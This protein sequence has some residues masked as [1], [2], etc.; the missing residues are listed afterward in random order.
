[1]A[2][3]QQPGFRMRKIAY[4]IMP[5]LLAI[6]GP[7]DA[8]PLSPQ[9]KVSEIYKL[10]TL[11]P[12]LKVDRKALDRFAMLN[13][14][15][16]TPGSREDRWFLRRAAYDLRKV[17]RQH[18]GYVCKQGMTRYGPEGGVAKGLMLTN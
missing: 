6:T 16:L 15:D 1:V 14:I 17:P 12:G 7:A 13:G 8:Q 2:P 9:E 11:C 5:A 3:A 18:S 4:L 10:I